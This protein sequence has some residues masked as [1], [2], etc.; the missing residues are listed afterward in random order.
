MTWALAE[1]K[2]KFSELVRRALEQG[3]QRV[4]RR[5]DI[6]VVIAEAEYLEL[7]GDKPRLVDFIAAAPELDKLDLSRDE[8][9]MRDVE[10]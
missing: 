8:T 7:T 4:S 3:P 5:G 2:N 9:T 1:A 6:V 10:F